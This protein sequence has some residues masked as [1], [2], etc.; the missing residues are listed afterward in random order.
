MYISGQ[1]LLLTALLLL[2]LDSCIVLYTLIY[3]RRAL[4]SSTWIGAI[5]TFTVITGLLFTS[6]RIVLEESRF[7][8]EPNM[9]EAVLG[10]SVCATVFV[11]WQAVTL[12]SAGRDTRILLENLVCITEAS[13]PN[14][15]G[16]ALYIQLL[17]DL[18]YHN[19]PVDERLRLNPE[20]LSYAALLIDVGQLGVP[21]QL[22]EK[23]GK[24]TDE[25]RAL[26]RRSPDI[27][28][29]IL[30]S[31]VSCKRIATWIRL[32]SEHVDGSG[33]LGVSGADLPLA[34]RILALASTFA[35]ITLSRTYKASR[36]CTE[37][38]EELKIVAGT[39]LDEELVDIFTQ[40]PIEQVEAC[41][42]TV[43]VRTGEIR[44]MGLE[45]PDKEEH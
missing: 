6:L 25:E 33:R 24:F 23:W 4:V 19:L 27:A 28:A 30:Q 36:S 34:A 12:R 11:V 15:N 26:M 44:R 40:I 31:S 10:M 8:S 14:L 38:M 20:E 43:R 35:A 37:A 42:E 2:L 3:R 41:L 29:Q 9:P 22:R 16:N 32:S 5:L 39:Q 21:R 45:T 13:A 17:S 1:Y 7:L 18:L